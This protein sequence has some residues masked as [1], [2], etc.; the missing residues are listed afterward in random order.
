LATG[1]WCPGGAVRRSSRAWSLSCCIW[2]GRLRSAL[3][4][5][6]FLVEGG[7]HGGEPLHDGLVADLAGVLPVGPYRLSGSAWQAQPELPQTV[8]TCTTTSR[9][10]RIDDAAAI[11]TIRSYARFALVL[12][13]GEA[14]PRDLKLG[15]IPHP[16]PRR[17]RTSGDVR[18]HQPRHHPVPATRSNRMAETR[19]NAQDPRRPRSSCWPFHQAKHYPGFA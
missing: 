3:V 16:P 8:R 13:P 5:D 4:A 15:Q 14:T 19:R 17:K 18:P 2:V 6:P 10:W 7:L 9:R 12:T 11:C 1:F